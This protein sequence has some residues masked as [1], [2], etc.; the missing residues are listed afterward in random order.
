MSPLLHSALSEQWNKIPSFKD[1]GELASAKGKDFLARRIADNHIRVRY[2]SEDLAAIPLFQRFN[3]NFSNL[4][5][6]LIMESG[7]LNF[8]LSRA[9]YASILSC[10][11]FVTVAKDRTYSH[12]TVKDV[13]EILSSS[14][15]IAKESFPVAGALEYDPDLK[16]LRIVSPNSLYNLVLRSESMT[17][18]D[19]LN[20]A[21]SNVFDRTGKKRTWSCV[22]RIARDRE[23][24]GMFRLK[25]LKLAIPDDAIQG[26]ARNPNVNRYAVLDHGLFASLL[27][28]RRIFY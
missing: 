28:S 10:T 15:D 2:E 26:P 9:L 5:M 20:L 6:S 19:M 27:I 4:A 14:K 21:C 11:R 3:G 17:E 8:D 1:L 16:A 25:N 24:G 18:T 23:D 12:Y 22:Y 7:Y 13:I